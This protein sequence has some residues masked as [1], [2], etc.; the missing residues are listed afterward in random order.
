MF[1]NL[2]K[3]FIGTTSTKLNCLSKIKSNDMQKIFKK[4]F[5]SITKNPKFNFQHSS[6]NAS[7]DKIKLVVKYG[8]FTLTVDN[9]LN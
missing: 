4:N 2:T 3:C 1:L 6:Q 7:P 9:F 5:K 8:L